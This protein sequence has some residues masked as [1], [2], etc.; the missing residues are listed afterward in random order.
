MRKKQSHVSFN[1]AS[2]AP[3]RIKTS[4]L[5]PDTC[6]III[7]IVIIIIIIIMVAVKLSVCTVL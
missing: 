2:R 6:I 5:R 1:S 7:I 3:Q 4:R